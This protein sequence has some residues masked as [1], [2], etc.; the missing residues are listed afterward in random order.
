MDFAISAD[1]REK[2][3]ESEEIDKYMDLTKVEKA[4]EHD[5]DGDT[6]YCRKSSQKPGKE[7]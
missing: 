3:K 2:I 1:H 7:N 5:C 4:V 6:N